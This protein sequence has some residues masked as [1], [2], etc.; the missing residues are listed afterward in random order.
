MELDE[1]TSDGK[2]RQWTIVQGEPRCVLDAV[3]P[4]D[5]TAP[6]VMGRNAVVSHMLAD[7]AAYEAASRVEEPPPDADNIDDLYAEWQTA[8]AIVVGA[9]EITMSLARI[10]GGAGTAGDEAAL[11]SA[12][13]AAPPIALAVPVPQDVELWRAREV[14]KRHDLLDRAFTIADDSGNTALRSFLE[15]GNAIS[16]NSPILASLAQALQL[17]PAQVDDMFVEANALQI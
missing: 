4:T 5:T 12:I 2:I 6:R 15:Y 9:S 13:D 7:V 8:R 1:Y 3:A 10:R 17:S 16:R 14:L 11:E